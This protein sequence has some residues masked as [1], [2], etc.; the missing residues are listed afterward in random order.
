L[1][2]DSTLDMLLAISHHMPLLYF[3]NAEDHGWGYRV[4]SSGHEV[5][6]FHNT[7]ML[8]RDE[9][10]FLPLAQTRFPQEEDVLYL[11]FGADSDAIREAFFAEVRQT[12]GYRKRFEQQ[13]E[14]TN[15]RAFALFEI[16]PEVLDRI[17][18]LLSMESF[19]TDAWTRV[20]V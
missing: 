10:L 1:N 8:D 18:R 6:S 3:E 7:Y 4:F 20:D 2:Q 17:D 16:A 15:V 14:N 11:F 9:K 12:D 5:A 13:F 19:H